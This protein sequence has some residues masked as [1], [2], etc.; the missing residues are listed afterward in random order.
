MRIERWVQEPDSP[1][2]LRIFEGFSFYV[3]IQKD[4]TGDY[5]LAEIITGRD[6]VTHTRFPGQLLYSAGDYSKAAEVLEY[7]QLIADNIGVYKKIM[8]EGDED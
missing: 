1:Y 3:E 2:W 7:S 4:R 6:G 5:P 8:A